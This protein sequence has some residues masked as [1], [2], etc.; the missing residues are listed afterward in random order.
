MENKYICI[1]N[2]TGGKGNKIQNQDERKNTTAG[3]NINEKENR[4]KRILIDFPPKYASIHN[5]EH[6][7]IIF[8]RFHSEVGV[9]AQ[10]KREKKS[11]LKN[12]YIWKIIEWRKTKMHTWTQRRARYWQKGMSSFSSQFTLYSMSSNNISIRN[13]NSN[14]LYRRGF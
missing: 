8:P 2:E 1:W 4:Q 13:F 14:Y 10:S 12:A 9:C 6:E 3:R 11:L 5:R 7:M